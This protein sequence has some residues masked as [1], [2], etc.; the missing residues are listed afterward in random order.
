MNERYRQ[1][2]VQ[3]AVQQHSPGGTVGQR[4]SARY[5]FNRSDRLAMILESSLRNLPY[6]MCTTPLG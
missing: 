1:N 3:D 4:K 2:N 5:G 6:G